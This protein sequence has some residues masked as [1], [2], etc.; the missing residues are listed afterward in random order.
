MTEIKVL[1][2]MIAAS[3]A[4]LASNVV[5]DW[6]ASRNITPDEGFGEG[7]TKIIAALLVGAITWAGGY[8]KASRTSAVSTAFDPNLA[9]S[10]SAKRGVL[11]NERGAIQTRTIAISALVIAGVIAAILFLPDILNG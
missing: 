11:P 9:L 7:L 3:V 2:A 10:T 1:A 4:A 5:V 6:L 8:F